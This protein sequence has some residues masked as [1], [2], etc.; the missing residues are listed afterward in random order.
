MDS[1]K[2]QQLE[3]LRAKVDDRDGIATQQHKKITNLNA[4]ELQFFAFKLHKS[5]DF[6]F[7]K[8]QQNSR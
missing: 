1:L 8:T 2:W 7:K 3:I 5:F 4:L 6:V